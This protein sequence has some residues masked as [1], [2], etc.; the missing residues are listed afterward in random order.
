M[1]RLIITFFAIFFISF[2]AFALSGDRKNIEFQ[3]C[4][5]NA[6]NDG[7]TKKFANDYCRC[8]ADKIDGK[9]TDNQLDALVYQGYDYM[10]SKLKP[11]A[12]K[13]YDKIS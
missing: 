2:N 12:K 9:Y 6:L 13:C 4:Y 11:I 5:I 1:K 8:F 10:I 3:S 7:S